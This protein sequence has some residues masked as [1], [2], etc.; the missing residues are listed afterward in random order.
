MLKYL[1]MAVGV[2]LTSFYFFPFTFTFLPGVNTKMA[3]A[4]VGLVLLG[5]QLGRARNSIFSKDMVTISLYAL[6]VSFTS[7]IAVTLNETRDYTYV[8]YIISMWVWL[9]AAYV[10]VKYMRTVHGYISVELVCN[11]LIAVCVFQCISALVID[12]VPTVKN[13]ALTYIADLGPTEMELMKET[14]RLF[15][16]GAALDPA[17]SRFAAVLTIIVF[18]A[19]RLAATNRNKYLVGYILAFIFIAIVGNM[20]ARTT[21]VGVIIAL[22]FLL[23]SIGLHRMVISKSTGRIMLW[24]VG[25]LVVAVPLLTIL[26]HTNEQ[27]HDNIRFAFEGFFSLAEKGR[28]EVNSNE[29]LK[30]MIVF[31]DNLKTWLIGDGYMVNPN[32]SDPYYTG[33]YHQA[34]YYQLTDIGYLRFIFYSGLIGLAAMALFIWKAGRISMLKFKDQQTLFWL[35]LAVNYV[36]WFKVSTDIFLALALFLVIDKE[37]NE[38]Y[39]EQFKLPE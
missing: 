22:A 14:G 8:S 11:Y 12:F 26:Y 13:F 6:M 15:G 19:T 30:N 1:Q 34:G 23:Y 3:M 9:S 32:I 5:L 20:I 39:D 18:M 21:T 16:F 10:A 27:F 2:I 28:W 17:G 25:V 4:G 33:E 7:F 31:H 29:I 38:K 35:L 36:V 24:F 37:E